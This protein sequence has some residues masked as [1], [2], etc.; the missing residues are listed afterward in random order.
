MFKAARDAIISNYGWNITDGGLDCPLE[1]VDNELEGLKIYP[2]PTTGVLNIHSE[3]AISQIEIYN[4]LGQLVQSNTDQVSIDIS[5]V[6]QG[7][8]FV[9]VMD[10]N[11]NVGTQKVVKK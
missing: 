3:T 4:L 7:I 9:K 8:Y 1:I 2:S 5:S 11:G 6:D 10:E